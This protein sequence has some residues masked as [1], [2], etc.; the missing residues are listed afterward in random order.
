MRGRR[1]M[2]SR[3]PSP[4]HWIHGG[5]GDKLSLTSGLVSR[6]VLCKRGNADEQTKTSGIATF[7]LVLNHVVRL[8][9]PANDQVSEDDFILIHLVPSPFKESFV[10][11][12]STHL[13]FLVRLS[14]EAT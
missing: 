14:K 12:S 6:Q 8:N 11:Y 5:G 2:S 7:I 4:C 10:I 3:R 9:R 13:G 1:L